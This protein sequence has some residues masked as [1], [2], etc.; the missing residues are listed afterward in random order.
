ML[1]QTT[2]KFDVRLHGRSIDIEQLHIPSYLSAPNGFNTCNKHVVTVCRNYT[3]LSDMGWQQKYTAFCNLTTHS[4][5]K[6]WNP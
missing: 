1:S 6:L 5:D 3:N 4:V 2:D